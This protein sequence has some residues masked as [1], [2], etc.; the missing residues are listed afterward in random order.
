[1][2]VSY[3]FSE[4]LLNYQ[5]GFKKGTN[6]LKQRVQGEIISGWKMFKIFDIESDH[7]KSKVEQAATAWSSNEDDGRKGNSICF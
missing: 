2:C 5:K 4:I 7:W 6:S 3:S 1:M